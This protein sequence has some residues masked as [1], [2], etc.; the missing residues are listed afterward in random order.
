MKHMK[1]LW[2]LAA[3]GW[4][5]LAMLT[6]AD[7]G[8][9]WEM[10]EVQEG[11]TMPE[12]IPVNLP[13]ALKDQFGGSSQRTVKHYI[14]DDGYRIDSGDGIVITNYRTM[15]VYSIDPGEKTYFKIDV[16]GFGS[17][18]PAIGEMAR[19]M[20]DSITITP[21]DQVEKIAGY[22][23]RKY[24]VSSMMGN[25]E[26]WASTKVGAYPLLKKAGEKMGRIMAENPMLSQLNVGG[27]MDKIEGFPVRSVMNVMGAK[28]TTTL[29]HIESRN[30]DKALFEVPA[31]FRET[32]MPAFE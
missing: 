9:Y 25:G 12:G 1:W 15:A 27:L 14:S 3:A 23:C 21:T 16:Q 30:I 7:A 5:M 18:Q 24:T 13:Q 22:D 26:Y 31:G 6:T 29:K 17:D 10:I 4:L 2:A 11:M 28:T 20:K 19:V 32:T 8:F